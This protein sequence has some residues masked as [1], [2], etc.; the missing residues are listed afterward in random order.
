MPKRYGMT[1]DP[2]RRKQELKK[3]YSGVN[4]FKIEKKFPNKQAAQEWENKKPNS[5]PGGPK[6]S[7]TYYG[8]S[9]SYSK[10]KK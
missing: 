9:H 10:K 4:S 6:T 3:E 5:H 2:N 7:G 8:Y 1:N